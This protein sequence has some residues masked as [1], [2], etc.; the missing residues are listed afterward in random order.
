MH[1]FTQMYTR[2]RTRTYA[3]T[4]TNVHWPQPAIR[5]RMQRASSD[6]M[7]TSASLCCTLT[8]ATLSHQHQGVIEQGF[9]S[10]HPPHRP[11]LLLFLRFLH[12]HPHLP[13]AAAQW[14]L[15]VMVSSQY[16]QR[17][18]HKQEWVY[19][20]TETQ[21]QIKANKEKEAKDGWS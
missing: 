5:Y 7:L 17:Q 8:S 12:C 19:T 21:T 16:T 6:S 10:S 11:L 4:N 3:N 20:E 15:Q 1:T 13:T 2:T 18:S 9:H 14:H